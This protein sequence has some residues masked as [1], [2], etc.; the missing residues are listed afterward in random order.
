VRAR[1]LPA[2]LT[3]QTAEI[4]VTPLD[5]TPG[6]VC[7]VGLTPADDSGDGQAWHG[8]MPPRLPG[9]Y[10]MSVEVR[11]LPHWG[12]IATTDTLV[13]LDTATERDHGWSSHDVDDEDG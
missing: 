4:T 9:R 2:P 3:G 5:D 11:G 6:T 12:T 8:I 7:N 1:L 13:V 10:E